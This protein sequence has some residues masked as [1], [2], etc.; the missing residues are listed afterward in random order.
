MVA[1]QNLEITYHNKIIV[2]VEHTIF[3]KGHVNLLVGTS[4]SGKT[5]LL[6]CMVGLQTSY[7]GAILINNQDITTIN[8][9]DYNKMIGFVCQKSV[10]FNHL[11]L[12][13]NCLQPLLLTRACS[14]AQALS[15]VEPLFAYFGLHEQRNQYPKTL[16]GGQ[17]QRA[18]LARALALEPSV[19]CLDEPS[20]AL[21]EV[22]SRLVA[23]KLKQ[24]AKDNKTVIVSSQDS[25]LISL[26]SD[27]TYRI[28]NTNLTQD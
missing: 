8:R 2:A 15:I 7:Q 14:T 9:H 21:D 16:S 10:L 25:F 6:Q 4:G 13:E 27:T 20:S 28:E 26:L 22:N 17:R 11:T 3:S 24:Y 18:A 23:D 12:V 19:V 5:S 1:L